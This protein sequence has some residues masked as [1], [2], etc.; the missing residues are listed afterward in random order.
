MFKHVAAMRRYAISLM[1]KTYGGKHKDGS[2]IYDEYQLRHLTSLLCF[3]DDDEARSACRHYNITVKTKGDGSDVVYWKGTLFREPKDPEKGTVIPLRPRKMIKTIEGKLH[4]ATRLAVCRGQ[5]SG[6]ESYLSP[7]ALEFLLA[8]SNSETN[9]TREIAN[10]NEYLRN[11]RDAVRQ[12]QVESLEAQQKEI[13][14]RQKRDE[15]QRLAELEMRRKNEEEMKRRIHLEEQQQR[16]AH[17]QREKE[18]LEKEQQE[19]KLRLEIEEKR[20]VEEQLLLRQEAERQKK[21]EQERQEAL[22]LQRECQIREEAERN[23]RAEEE[24]E[25][26]RALEMERIRKEREEEVQRQQEKQRLLDVLQAQELERQRREAERLHKLEQLRKQSNAAHKIATWIWRIIRGQ[27]RTIACRINDTLSTLESRNRSR[28]AFMPFQ[29]MKQ[30]PLWE[31]DE[32]SNR[33]AAS[34]ASMITCN[35]SSLNSLLASNICAHF[36]AEKKHKNEATIL[37]T[38]A[39]I[40]PMG[41]SV[42]EQQICEMIHAWLQ[43]RFTYNEVFDHRG[44]LYNVR[45]VIYDNIN[46]PS[47]MSTCDAAIFVVPPPLADEADNRLIDIKSLSTYIDDD[48]PRMAI[49]FFDRCDSDRIRANNAVLSDA[50]SGSYKSISLVG[51]VGTSA[52]ALEESALDCIEKARNLFA[53]DDIQTINRTSVERI[54]YRCVSSALWMEN[55]ESRDD[56]GRCAATMIQAIIKELEIARLLVEP[57]A[58]TWSLKAFALSTDAVPIVA[59]YFG[60]GSHLPVDWASMEQYT[61]IDN[62][63]MEY[64]N[65]LKGPITTSIHQLIADAPYSVRANCQILMDQQFFKRCLQAALQWKM[66]KDE[67]GLNCRY[68]YLPA[69]AIEDVIHRSITLFYKNQADEMKLYSIPSQERVETI[70]LGHSDVPELIDRPPQETPSTTSKV[71]ATKRLRFSDSF[72]PSIA[73]YQGSTPIL[74]SQTKSSSFVSTGSKRSRTIPKVNEQDVVSMPKHMLDSLSFTEKLHNLLHGNDSF[75]LMIGK[76]FFLSTALLDAPPLITELDDTTRQ[77]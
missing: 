48:V 22:R 12:Q 14:E 39:F 16:Q 19:L 71:S 24:R 1:S 7:A 66:N 17:L 65:L 55:F 11:M 57:F 15:A 9:S 23:R 37:L 28:N 20:R 4:G 47:A 13:I 44:I 31:Y 8:R 59:D 25:R 76:S 29:T 41:G 46:P 54:I 62:A 35:Q 33:L 70:A 63:F 49:A 58:S 34:L 69:G 10:Q 53:A 56:I 32:Y 67:G 30:I 43:S 72:E 77:R 73:K 18:K 27:N 52:S 45:I 21:A 68:V 26:Q 36:D 74:D 42:Q 2:N 6:T 64:F 60:T 38:L 75:D 5:L 40:F 3:E 50:L 61:L 51:N